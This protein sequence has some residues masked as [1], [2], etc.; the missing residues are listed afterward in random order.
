MTQKVT[1]QVFI[2]AHV[3]CE[4]SAMIDILG[5][6]HPSV[7]KRTDHSNVCP[8]RLLLVINAQTYSS[9]LASGLKALTVLPALQISWSSISFNSFSRSFRYVLRPLNSSA[10]RVSV[11]FFTDSYSFSK[12]GLL[13]ASKIGAQSRAPRR[14]VVEHACRVA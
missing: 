11:P 3:D 8:M 12:T 14:A 9:L 6:I 7:G 13:A 4:V 10:L 2:E 5:D 1:I